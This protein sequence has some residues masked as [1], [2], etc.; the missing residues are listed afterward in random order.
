MKYSV[1]HYYKCT[2]FFAYNVFFCLILII[3]VISQHIIIK[4]LSTQ[5]SILWEP[6][7]AD[8]QLSRQTDRPTDMALLTVTVLS[9]VN[10]LDN[11]NVYE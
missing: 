1:R 10:K 5:K 7:D 8:E 3:T 4:V 9:F 6:S 2:N 11:S